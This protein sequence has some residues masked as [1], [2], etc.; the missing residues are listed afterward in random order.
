MNLKFFFISDFPVGDRQVDNE[1]LS[2]KKEMSRSASSEQ[3]QQSVSKTVSKEGPIASFYLLSSF[4][5][6]CI[7]EEK[8]FE[9]WREKWKYQSPT[10]PL[11][12]IF[13]EL[14]GWKRFWKKILMQQQSLSRVREES[15]TSPLME[16]SSIQNLK[17]VG[18]RSRKRSS[19]YSDNMYLPWW[20]SMTRRAASICLVRVDPLSTPSRSQINPPF[21]SAGETPTICSW[22]FPGYLANTPWSKR[23]RTAPIT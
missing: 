13:R 1:M 10:A 7:I 3:W 11:E 9:E 23:N 2:D 19:G 15:S 6:R 14:P 16:R 4:L 17:Q 18:S 22:S 20:A 12:I 5:E 8:M 21:V